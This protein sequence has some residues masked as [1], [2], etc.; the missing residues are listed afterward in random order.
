MRSFSSVPLAAGLA[1]AVLGGAAVAALAPGATI[2]VDL[3]PTAQAG[4]FVWHDLLTD[5][6]EASRKFYGALFGWTFEDGQ[7]IDPGYTIIKDGGQPIG[8]LVTVKRPEPDAEIAQ[9]LVYVMVPEVDAAT[10]AFRDAGGR[11]YR[12]PLD[13]RSDLRV[14]IVAD[15]QGAPIGL[16]SRGTKFAVEMPPP[17]N[18]WLWME[19]LAQDAPTALEFYSRVIGFTSE[20]RDTRQNF[21]YHVLKTDRPRA[22]LFQSPWKRDASAWLPYLRVEDPTAMAQRVKQLGGSILLAPE[23]NIRN[24]SLAIVLD[25]TGA[26]LALQKFPFASPVT[27]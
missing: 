26:P 9:W 23:P 8:G 7:G 25:P 5:D 2:D 22:G 27:P 11:V 20:I 15:G 21:I 3:A 12:G 6:A 18:R 24:G 19:Y 4:E 13:A 14:A 17:I 10:K 16:A 1:V